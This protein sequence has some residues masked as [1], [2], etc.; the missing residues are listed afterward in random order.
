MCWWSD[1]FSSYTWFER[2]I[3]Q[4]STNSTHCYSQPVCSTLSSSLCCRSLALETLSLDH[5]PR[6]NELWQSF[7]GICFLF[8]QF[9]WSLA[10]S[11]KSGRESSFSDFPCTWDR[12]YCTVPQASEWS[13][14]QELLRPTARE[15][16][17]GCCEQ[18]NCLLLSQKLLC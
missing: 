8:A 6:L 12:Q 18:N 4:T 3:R 9:L 1:F 14:T 16:N 13:R 2:V 15:Q 11:P 17:Q 5:S 10:S 7:L